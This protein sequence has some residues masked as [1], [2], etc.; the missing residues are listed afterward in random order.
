MLFDWKHKL[1]GG[2]LLAAFVL[3][4]VGFNSWIKS[5]DAQIE[6]E[7]TVKAQQVAFDKAGQQIK[8]LE[9]ADSARARE[10]ATKVQIIHDEAQKQTPPAEIAEY[11]AAKWGL[12]GQI[13]AQGDAKDSKPLDAS[14]PLQIAPGDLPTLRDYT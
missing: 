9:D 14:A 4:G 13:Q 2:A 3:I 7:A 5:H 10:T 11:L 8:A 6:A 1:L 12:P